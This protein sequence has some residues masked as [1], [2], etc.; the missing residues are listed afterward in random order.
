MSSYSYIHIRGTTHSYVQPLTRGGRWCTHSLT[1]SLSLSLFSLFSLF[2]LPPL[3]LSLSLSLFCTQNTHRGAIQGKGL[4]S[5]KLNAMIGM[6][7]DGGTNS[8]FAGN[9]A[10]GSERAGFSGPGVACG[11]TQSFVQ[12]VAHSVLAGYWFDFYRTPSVHAQTG[13][14]A[15][16]DFTAWKIWEYGIYGETLMPYVHVTGAKVLDSK[17]GIWLHMGGASSL[18]HVIQDTKVVIKDSL[19]VGHSSNGNCGTIKPSL[20]T[21]TFYMAWC[22]HVGPHHVGIYMSAFGSGSNLAPTVRPWFDSGM[23]PALYGHSEVE[24]VTFAGFGLP[25]T[26]GPRANKRDYAFSGVPDKNADSWYVCMYVC[27]YTIDIDQ[28]TRT[29]LIHKNTDLVFDMILHIYMYISNSNI[30]LFVRQ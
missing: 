16:T 15:L 9:I 18:S 11:D 24:D 6:F 26:S 8:K 3:S 30:Y 27:I 25:C 20:Y 23:Y 12:N 10:A 29:H 21:C 7:H 14:A 5:P 2:S 19:I 1:L 13:C 22:N 4:A 17:V 28:C